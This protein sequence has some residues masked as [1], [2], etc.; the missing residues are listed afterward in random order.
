M[1]RI[2]NF[3]VLTQDM[4]HFSIELKELDSAKQKI[5]T[6]EDTLAQERQESESR[7]K[8]LERK[9]TALDLLT[10]HFKKDL[11]KLDQEKREVEKSLK[12]AEKELAMLIAQRE[13]DAKSHMARE[14]AKEKKLRDLKTKLD[15]TETRL[16]QGRIELHELKSAIGLLESDEDLFVAAYLTGKVL[17]CPDQKFLRN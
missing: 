16:D 2:K 4:L 13:R 14:Q 15:F 5:R 3:H 1:E 12:E 8:E 6:L 11:A 7:E 10:Q 17:N 9:E